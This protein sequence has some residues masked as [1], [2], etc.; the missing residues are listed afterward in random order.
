MSF[1]NGCG[2]KV[3]STH[4]RDRVRE[5]DCIKYKIDKLGELLDFFVHDNVKGNMY[6]LSHSS[7]L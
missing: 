3:E 6:T 2:L 4:K 5:Y 1:S 7:Y